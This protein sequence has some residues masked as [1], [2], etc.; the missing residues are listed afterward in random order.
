MKKRLFMFATAALMLAACSNDGEVAVNDVVSQSGPS[1]VAFDTYTASATKA[2]QTGVMNTTQL[3]TTGFGV[4]ASL[5]NNGDYVSTIGPNFM[6]DEEVEYAASAWTYSPLKYW[7]NETTVDML[8]AEGHAS[9]TATDKLSFFAYAPYVEATTAG[10][11]TATNPDQNNEDTPENFEAGITALSANNVTTDPIVS[12]AMA[13][14]PSKSVD[15][16]WGVAPSGGLSYKDVAN[17]TVSVPSGEPL[18][19]LTKPSKDQ[20]IKFLFKHALARLGLTVVAA[21]DQVAAGGNLDANTK[22]FVNSVTIEDAASPKVLAPTGTLNLN[23]TS[24][25]VANWTL[26]TKEKF[27]LVINSAKSNIN[28]DLLSPSGNGVTTAEKDVIADGKYFMIIPTEGNAK[29]KFKVTINYDVVTTDPALNGGKSAVNNVIWKEISVGDD[30]NGFTNNKA[31]K[32]KL[33]LGL[34]SVKLE[35]EVADWEVDGST[36][37]NL[38]KNEE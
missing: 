3:Q 25:G 7:P 20:K 33:I 34:T 10:V 13:Y 14:T 12:Y 22:I 1:A 31:Y 11:V 26:G 24:A 37:V 6:Y 19:N 15:L 28:T 30:I 18:K 38:P 4:F 32:L 21:V 5:S 8:N 29:A 27:N 9:S 36:N 16:L 2:G 23:N 17:N 35:A